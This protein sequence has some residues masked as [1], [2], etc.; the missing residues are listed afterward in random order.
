MDR[1]T[2]WATV[3]GVARIRHDL[4]AKQLNFFVVVVP[5]PAGDKQL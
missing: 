3:Q 2:W 1:E 5:F 4:V